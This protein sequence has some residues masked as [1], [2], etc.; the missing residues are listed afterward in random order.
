MELV[1]IVTEPLYS[2]VRWDNAPL[3]AMAD[4]IDEEWAKIDNDRVQGAHTMER[5]PPKELGF[6][7]WAKLVFKE[8]GYEAVGY[9]WWISVLQE[10][11]RTDAT[12][13]WV[14]GFPHR[15][16]WDHGRTLIFYVT[17]PEGGG[18]TT[19]HDDVKNE[20]HSIE[21]TP[22]MGVFVDGKVLHGVRPST[23][24]TRR[25]CLICTAF[26]AAHGRI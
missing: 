4:Y 2:T 9:K 26:T 8:Q 16:G 7:D 14:Q 25:R 22:G 23:G 1:Q 24:Q 20:I 21:C 13:N 5:P 11:S 6:E 12:H 10:Q 3:Q 15:H 19:V 17:S 18:E